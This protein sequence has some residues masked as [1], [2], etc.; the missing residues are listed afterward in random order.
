MNAAQEDADAIEVA[1]VRNVQ[2]VHT[3]CI[4]CGR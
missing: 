1:R 2:D 4:A 3:R